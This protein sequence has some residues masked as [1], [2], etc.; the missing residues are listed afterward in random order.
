MEEGMLVIML[1]LR[2]YIQSPNIK[3]ASLLTALGAVRSLEK[4]K[5]L[6]P[7]RAHRELENL[8]TV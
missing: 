3:L 6:G 4:G 7:W 5:K 1:K 2:F 8:V